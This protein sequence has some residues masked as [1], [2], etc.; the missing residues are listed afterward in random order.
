MESAAQDAVWKALADP[1]R[2]RLLD[3]LKRGPRT[4]GELC[5]PFKKLSRFAVMKH[6]GILEDAGLILIR[7]HGRERWNHLNAVPIQQIYERWV[8][9]Y[10]A[11]WSKHL[12]SLKTVVEATGVTDM[13]AEKKKSATWGMGQAEL[14]IPIQATRQRVWEALTQETSKWWSFYTNNAAKQFIIEPKLGGRVYEDWGNGSG[15]LW[16]TVLAVDPPSSLSMTGLVTPAWGGPAE[17]FVQF[18]LKASGKQTILQISNTVFGKVLDEKQSQAKEGWKMLLDDGL[19]Q[20]VE[21]GKVA[22]RVDWGH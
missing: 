16:F 6:L 10:A 22:A 21:T 5:Q 14:E 13:A 7:R 2:R 3:A 15:V 4:T 19:K 9:S 1:T 20:Y 18:T 12:V 8:R 11:Y 17:S